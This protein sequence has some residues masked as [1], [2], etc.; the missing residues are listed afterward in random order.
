MYIYIYLPCVK[1]YEEKRV[2][3]EFDEVLPYCTLIGVLA[4]ICLIVSMWN[5]YGWFSIPIVLLIFWGIIMSSNIVPSPF[6]GNVFFVSLIT[7]MLFSY[8]FIKGKGWTYYK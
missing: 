1:K 6:L 8:R 7:A 3:K 4:L 5:V 2:E